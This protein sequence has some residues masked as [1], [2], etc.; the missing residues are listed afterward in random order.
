[1]KST[2]DHELI[3]TEMFFRFN[4]QEF[5]FGQIRKELLKRGIATQD[6]VEIVSKVKETL[7]ATEPFNN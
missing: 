6:I 4:P 7:Q 5:G 2:I 3:A 1:M